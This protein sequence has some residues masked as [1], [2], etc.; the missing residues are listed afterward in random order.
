MPTYL[1]SQA[2]GFSLV[3]VLVAMGVLAIGMVAT[4]PLM[5]Y[6]TQRSTLARRESNAVSVGQDTLERL[7][8]EIR[9]DTG[10]TTAWD[11]VAVGAPTNGSRW[12]ADSLPHDLVESASDLPTMG[13]SRKSP[14]CAAEIGVEKIASVGADSNALYVEREGELYTVCYDIQ[15]PA[16]TVCPGVGCRLD[17]NVKVLWFGQNGLAQERRLASTVQGG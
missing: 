14:P 10:S 17:V 15:N 4:F 8:N 5:T 6:A 16:G 7:R 12:R 11:P 2:R 3:E 1:R 13:G 9:Y